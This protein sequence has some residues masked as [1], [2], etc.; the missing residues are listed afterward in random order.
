M[1]LVPSIVSR[2]PMVRSLT[3]VNV[4]LR[5]SYLYRAV[6]KFNDYNSVCEVSRDKLIWGILFLDHGF[7]MFLAE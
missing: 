7:G 6:A 3:L 1:A 5:K 4:P 2:N